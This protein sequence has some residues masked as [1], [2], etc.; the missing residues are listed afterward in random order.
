[1][2]RTSK[3]AFSNMRYHKSKNILIGIAVFLTTLL[4]FLVP[5]MGIDLINSQKAAV[6]ELYPTWHAVFR[7]VPEDNV[8]K[9]VSHHLVENY[10]IGGELGY[11]VTD[12]STIAMMYMDEHTLVMNKLELLQGRL[13]EKENEIVVSQGILKELELSG[14][15][16]D[17]ITIPYQVNRNGGLD[18]IRKKDFVIC[19]V[20]PDNKTN[21]EQK[22]YTLLVSK[23][24]LQE[25]IPSEQIR[26]SFMFQLDTAHANNT[27][28]MEESIKQLAEQFGVTEQDYRI[29][30]DYLWA[31]YVD[32][33]FIPIIIIIMLIIIMAGIIT[34]YSI[35][36]I[37]ME[38]RVR[39]FGKLKA[40]G[41]TTGQIRKI[42]LWEGLF[43]AGIA[44]PLGLIAGT[45]L[46]KCVYLSIFRFYQNENILM[47]T[48][49]NLIHRGEVKLI[50]PWIYLLTIAVT[51]C[52]V[53]LSLLR[54]MKK[55]ARVS[56]V[57]GR[58]A[59]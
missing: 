49:K 1:M 57:S 56:E 59:F 48:I 9:I 6:N 51:L 15:I 42:V 27:D 41:A 19:G 28:K 30:E 22:S 20:L 55:T 17:T 26:Y 52:T 36:Y 21:V 34:I 44:I 4:L 8:T 24:L 54:P 31:N 5:T 46:A 32:P 35:Y 53:F 39:E 50:V 58:A 40:I 7:E 45:L 38:E 14:E 2:S 18:F 47:S 13:P 3:I 43:V 37:T 16:G 10:G 29:N 23:A 25:E 12:D 33:S 11:A